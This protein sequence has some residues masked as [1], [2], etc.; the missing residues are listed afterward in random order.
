MGCGKQVGKGGGGGGLAH[1]LTAC[2]CS[3]R[4]GEQRMKKKMGTRATPIPKHTVLY[5]SVHVTWGVHTATGR[6]INR[7]PQLHL[8]MD[9]E[10]PSHANRWGRGTTT[11]VGRGVRAWRQAVWCV[12]ACVCVGDTATHHNADAPTPH[13]YTH[14]GPFTR[15]AAPPLRGS[16]RSPGRVRGTSPCPT[17]AARETPHCG[18][19]PKTRH[20][21]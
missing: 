10:Q 8:D 1:A 17:P 19:A 6:W 7:T 14:I 20:Q 3:H 18:P 11:K 21:R 5:M 2:A 13:T 16:L 4:G 15:D 9:A 12:C